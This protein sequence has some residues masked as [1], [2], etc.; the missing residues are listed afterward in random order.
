MALGGAAYVTTSFC[1]LRFYCKISERIDVK[2]GHAEIPL[3]F[4]LTFSRALNMTFAEC[5]PMIRRT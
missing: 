3:T 4:I 5:N 2:L 1:G